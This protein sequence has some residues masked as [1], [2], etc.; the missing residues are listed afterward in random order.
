[1]P[2]WKDEESIGT[3]WTIL[4]RAL[5]GKC[6]DLSPIQRLSF[7]NTYKIIDLYSS[8]DSCKLCVCPVFEN[9]I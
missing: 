2:S 9:N 6:D 1:M 4:V 3:L 5:S 7:W 8:T